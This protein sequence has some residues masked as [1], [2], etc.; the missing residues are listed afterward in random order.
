MMPEDTG[1]FY[2]VSFNDEAV[3]EADAAYL[4]RSRFTLPEEA[5][6]WYEGIFTRAGELY[7]WPRRYSLLPF[8]GFEGEV[9]RIIYGRGPSAYHIIYRVFD[10]AEG[11][12]AG[13]V[14]VLHVR[15]AA[16]QSGSGT[17]NNGED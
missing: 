4:R 13:I 9:R 16:G 8:S 5:A 10:P 11:E 3:A 1:I 2:E 17:T 12:T 15:P 7:Y 14:R 6:S